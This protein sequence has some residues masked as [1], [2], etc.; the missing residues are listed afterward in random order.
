M[1]EACHQP[2]GPLASMSEKHSSID[3][4]SLEEL[5]QAAW[6]ALENAVAFGN[7]HVGSAVLSEDG[8]IFSGCNIEHRLR[9]HDI[10]A[11]VCA[12]A[13]MVKSGQQRIMAILVVANIGNLTPCGGCIDWIAQFGDADTPVITQSAR[14]GPYSFYTLSEIA[15]HHPLATKNTQVNGDHRNA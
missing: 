8:R 12:I 15:P 10:H 2:I 3:E 13:S 9:C 11:E 7:T 4:N 6:L 14:S 5:S 1:S